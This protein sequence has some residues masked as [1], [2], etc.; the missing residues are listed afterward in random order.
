[1]KRVVF[2]FTLALFCFAIAQPAVAMTVPVE[3]P[4]ASPLNVLQTAVADLAGGA[5]AIIA[6]IEST[7]GNLAST[8]TGHV[9]VASNTASA[10]VAVTPSSTTV[11]AAEAPLVTNAPTPAPPS[12]PTVTLPPPT[13][14]TTPPTGAASDNIFELQSAVAELTK[15][16]QGLTALFETQTPSSKIESQIA[17]LQSA[18]SAQGPGQSYNAAA[19]PPLGGGSPN[20]I[21]AAGAIDQLSGVT[22]TNA[23]LTASEIPALSYLSTSGGTVA[24]TINASGFDV[25]GAPYVDNSATDDANSLI[26]GDLSKPEWNSYWDSS[27]YA[28]VT[29]A[30]NY[31]SDGSYED[32]VLVNR[33]GNAP[34]NGMMSVIFVPPAGT[35]S[36]TFNVPAMLPSGVK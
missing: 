1:M 27:G 21:A 8:I 15:G 28:P 23:N 24:G 29:I 22:I 25:N 11:T 36:V 10:A 30:P 5:E 14:L 26:D 34:T 17:T 4:A 7:V 31:G 32:G 3:A 2:C 16:V 33:D 20:T 9:A 18:L 6:S 12:I 19:S 35:N 13:V